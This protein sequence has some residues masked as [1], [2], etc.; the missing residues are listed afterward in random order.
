MRRH[1]PSAMPMSSVAG[2]DRRDDALRKIEVHGFTVL[3][4]PR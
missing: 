2:A 1:L 3:V 4:P